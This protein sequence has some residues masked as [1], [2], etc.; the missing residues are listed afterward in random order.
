MPTYWIF[1]IHGSL[2]KNVR[3]LDAMTDLLQRGTTARLPAAKPAEPAPDRGLRRGWVGAEQ[4][5]PV[6]PAIDTIFQSARRGGSGA[7]TL[8]RKQEIELEN[9]GAADYLGRGDQ[10]TP[11]PDGPPPEQPK[12]S[13]EVVWG[14][15]TTVD[16]DVYAVGH[17]EGVEPQRAEL[18]LDEAVSGVKPGGSYDRRRLVITQHTRRGMLRGALGDV[19]FFP[20]G[21]AKH[22]DRVAAVAGM[23]R[24]GDVRPRGAQASRSGAHGLDRHAAE[25]TVVATVLIGSGEG[26]LTIVDAVRGLVEGFNDAVAEIAA[27][28]ELRLVL[29]VTKLVIVERERGRAEE[30]L[31]ALH[32]VLEEQKTRPITDLRLAVDYQAKPTLT[33][34]RRGTVSVEESV[35]LLADVAVGFAAARPTSPDGKA[36][37]RLLAD[38]PQSKQ[39]QSI[40]LKRLAAAHAVT[41]KSASRPRFRVESRDAQQLRPDVAVRVS[42][43][44]DGPA[45]RAAAIHQAATVP[46]RLITVSS[47]VIDDLVER[48]TDPPAET[49]DDLCRLLYRLLVPADFREVLRSRS[50][51]LRG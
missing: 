31:E 21:D 26:T 18:A 33:R 39:V 4:I 38:I 22:P 40:A 29:P 35:A 23:G 19:S 42:F 16:A 12:V 14:D 25:G 15:V 24:P 11:M 50:V 30:I 48:M 37:A 28:E 46:E 7:P 51:R 13:V 34:G 41:R 20:W 8:T 5:E 43:W 27:S 32:A 10:A 6:D 9:L 49:V 3:V 47:D 1:E 17:Y 2:A 36:L 45:I 44:S